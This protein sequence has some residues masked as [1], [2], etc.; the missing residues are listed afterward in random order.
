M[1]LE[2]SGETEKEPRFW[3]ADHFEN[4]KMHDFGLPGGGN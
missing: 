3:W 1:T 4:W 2:T